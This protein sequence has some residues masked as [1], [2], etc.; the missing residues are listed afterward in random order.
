MRSIRKKTEI[1]SLLVALVCVA[2]KCG[3]APPIGEDRDGPPQYGG[4]LRTAFFLDVRTLDAAVAFDTGAA[5][6]EGMIYDGLVTYDDAGKIVPQLAESFD[7]SPD[8]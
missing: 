1:K 7:V 5:A 8:Q 2:C 3:V 4:T 6:I